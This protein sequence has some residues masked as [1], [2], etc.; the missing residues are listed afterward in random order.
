MLQVARLAPRLLGDS[1][2]LVVAFLRSQMNADGGFQN[3]AG[4]SDLYYTVFG[5]EGLLA[6]RADVP[7]STIV[8]YLCAFDEVDELDFVHASCLA[9]GWAAMPPDL[10]SQSPRQQ[11]LQR[12]ASFRTADGAYSATPGAAQGTLYGCF[13]A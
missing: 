8:D 4:D 13:L 7:H 3:R 11:I 2:E 6:L 5:L 1:A 10:R 9:R 12:I